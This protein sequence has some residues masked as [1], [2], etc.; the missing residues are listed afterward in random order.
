MSNKE[1][2]MTISSQQINELSI[3]NRLALID[4]L[5]ESINE[6]THA[7]DISMT[8]QQRT[9]IR[10]RLQRYEKGEVKLSSW[11]EVKKRVKAQ[12]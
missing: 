5:W 1:S 7:D 10:N 9:E 8:P 3:P 6:D 2:N 4:Q 12:I 11:Q